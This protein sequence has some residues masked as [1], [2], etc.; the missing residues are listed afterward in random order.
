[1]VPA[2]EDDEIYI[3]I[4][5]ISRNLKTKNFKIHELKAYREYLRRVVIKNVVCGLSMV[6]NLIMRT[7]TIIICY[8]LIS[9]WFNHSNY[10]FYKK[11]N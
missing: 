3:L 1:M 2:E 6:I 5:K 8:K 10:E 11:K 7:K 9:L 4:S